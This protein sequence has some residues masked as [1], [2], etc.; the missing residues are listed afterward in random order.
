MNWVKFAVKG[1]GE[2]K[3]GIV[4]GFGVILIRI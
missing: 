3:M 4:E 2:I 1:C